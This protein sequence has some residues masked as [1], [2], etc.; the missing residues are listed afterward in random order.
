MADNDNRSRLTLI[1]GGK[2][3]KSHNAATKLRKIAEIKQL[4]HESNFSLNELESI[5]IKLIMMRF[6]TSN[7][8]L[9]GLND[10]S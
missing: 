2:K 10:Q 5:R 1:P 8:A 4:L 7:L 6:D 9:G 3:D